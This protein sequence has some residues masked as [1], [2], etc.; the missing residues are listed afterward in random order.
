MYTRDYAFS[1]YA[2]SIWKT[3]FS[4][5]KE[6][7]NVRYLEVG[8]FEGRSLLWIYENILPSASV[9]IDALDSFPFPD[10]KMNFTENVSHLIKKNIVK[11]LHGTSEQLI[12]N[13]PRL[14]Y[15]LIYLDADHTYRS[16]WNDTVL[17]WPALKPGGFLVLDDYF[18]KKFE[19]P[20]ADRPEQA[21][22][23]FLMESKGSYR[24]L[25]KSFQVYLQ[26]LD[27]LPVRM[28]PLTEKSSR[29][30]SGGLVLPGPLLT[31]VR[32]LAAL[33]LNVKRKFFNPFYPGRH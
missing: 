32:R 31:I 9:E 21:I 16:V 24:M 23:D 12:K 7:T 30:P 28:Q 10:T 8:V 11:I 3:L 27:E 18:W 17:L 14:Y 20:L 4:E 1:E 19:V 6:K 26:K 5:L 15:D 25:Y 33:L 29:I 13:L 22:D 2:K